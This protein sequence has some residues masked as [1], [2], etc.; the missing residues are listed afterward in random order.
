MSEQGRQ[1]WAT[2]QLVG[3]V[4]S[5]IPSCIWSSVCLCDVTHW[6]DGKLLMDSRLSSQRGLGEHPL[7]DCILKLCDLECH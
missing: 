3:T 1:P 5:G 2:L 6:K 4:S 7:D